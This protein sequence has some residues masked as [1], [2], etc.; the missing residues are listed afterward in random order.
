MDQYDHEWV[1]NAGKGGE[2]TYKPNPSTSVKTDE[3]VANFECKKCGARTWLTQA[4]FE[5]TPESA[6]A[7]EVE[8]EKQEEIE[9]EQ[10]E[11]AISDESTGEDEAGKE[12]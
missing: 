2:P 11:E 3:P 1:A 12:E 5:G 6:P 8:E 7:E 4:Q 9:S 10:T